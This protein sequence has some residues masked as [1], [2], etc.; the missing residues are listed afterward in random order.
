MICCPSSPAKLGSAVGEIDSGSPFLLRGPFPF[1]AH[2]VLVF[3]SAMR[4]LPGRKKNRENVRIFLVKL[5]KSSKL[6]K[7]LMINGKSHAL[8]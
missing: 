2:L 5:P 8:G 3:T 6:A 7:L 4:I 1:L